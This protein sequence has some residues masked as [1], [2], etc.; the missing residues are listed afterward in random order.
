MR[1][2]ESDADATHNRYMRRCIHLARAA[3]S[4]GNTPVGSVVVIDDQIVGEGVEE[5]PA[6]LNVAGHA[7]LLACQAAID[8][9]GRRRL[10]SA[11]L[12]TTAEPCFMCSYA[13]R[14][15]EISLVV[16]GVDTPMIGGI[17]SEFPILIDSKLT[18]WRPA[19]LCLGGVLRDECERL[20]S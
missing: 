15:C 19:P 4:R 1:G 5:L 12:Y 20:K 13:I 9:L 3:H 6:G 2:R 7:E 17:T 10:P 18:D 8:L 14:D 16:Y 11:T